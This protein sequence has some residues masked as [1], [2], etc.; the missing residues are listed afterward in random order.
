[1]RHNERRMRTFNISMLWFL[2]LLTAACASERRKPISEQLKQ[3]FKTADKNGDEALDR[4]EFAT[5]TLPDAKFEDLDTDNNGKVTL[6]E[7]KSYVIWRRV[8][9]EGRRRYKEIERQD[10]QRHPD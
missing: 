2:V 4:D 5:F 6:A 7:V 3:E 10:G 9:A 1:M 8:Q